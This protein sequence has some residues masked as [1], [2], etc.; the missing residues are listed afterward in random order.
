[1]F[2]LLGM[3][4]GAVYGGSYGSIC[5]NIPG[6]AAAAA[7]AMDGYPL[8]CK[9]EAGRALGLTTT[10]S[11]IGTM[12][13]M[14]FLAVFAPLISRL[15]LQFTSFEF[16]LLAF[17]GIMISGGLTGQDLI[18]KGWISGLIGLFLAV[19]GRDNLQFFPRFTF[20]IPEFDG[21]LEVVPVLIGAFGIPQII[22]VIRDQLSIGGAI[23]PLLTL[24]VPGSPPAAMLLGALMIHNVTPGPMISIEHP[25]FITEVTAILMLAPFAMFICGILLAQQVGK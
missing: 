4:V 1:M 10:A 23:I 22:Q 8:A 20:G 19:I 11:F 2:T 16:F 25:H 6:T 21:G 3:Y 14:F 9:G 12:V 5:V 13:G 17:F 18:Y 24:G 15:A 7:T